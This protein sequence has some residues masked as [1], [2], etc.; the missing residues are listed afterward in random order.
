MCDLCCATVQKR[1]LIRA[2][3]FDGIDSR[4][5]GQIWNGPRHCNNAHAPAYI[6]LP[7][8]HGYR[9]LPYSYQ[10]C[11]TF[12]GWIV[13][14]TLAYAILTIFTKL[15]NLESRDFYPSRGSRSTIGSKYIA[16]GFWAERKC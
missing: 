9:R 5:D 8:L 15:I 16:D 13:L 14:L 10:D 12:L 1:A 7:L 4:W 3:I 11:C 6:S 2:Y